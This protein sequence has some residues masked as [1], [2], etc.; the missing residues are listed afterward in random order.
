MYQ[1]DD[2]LRLG[3]PSTTYYIV[4]A[5]SVL[6]VVCNLPPGSARGAGSLSLAA[7]SVPS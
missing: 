7:L 6:L 4:Q 3:Y 1:F 2:V 5:Y